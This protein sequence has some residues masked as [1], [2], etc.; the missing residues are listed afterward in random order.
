[1]EICSVVEQ[2]AELRRSA[3][4]PTSPAA[5]AVVDQLLCVMEKTE[6]DELLSPASRVWAACLGH[7]A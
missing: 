5:H 1:M 3:F 7:S 2:N 6:Y 4:K